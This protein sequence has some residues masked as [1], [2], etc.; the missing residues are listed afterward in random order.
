MPVD[1]YSIRQTSRFP[2]K[3]NQVAQIVKGTVDAA[4]EAARHKIILVLIY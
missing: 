1:F 3:S 4:V 2:A